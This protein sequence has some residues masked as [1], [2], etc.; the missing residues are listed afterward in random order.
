MK[1]LELDVVNFKEE[2]LTPQEGEERMSQAPHLILSGRHGEILWF[3][4][5]G[6]IIDLLFQERR[7]GHFGLFPRCHSSLSLDLLLFVVLV[8]KYPC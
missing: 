1:C 2:F 7:V 6:V 8:G 5:L 3:S 4:L